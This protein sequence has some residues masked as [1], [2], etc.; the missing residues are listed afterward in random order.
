MRDI[1]E[2]IEKNI[3]FEMQVL[4]LRKNEYTVTEISSILH[5]SSEKVSNAIKSLTEK[6]LPATKYK[7]LHGKSMLKRKQRALE[8]LE[9][10]KTVKE[11]AYELEVSIDTV[12]KYIKE[13]IKDGKVTKEVL[14]RNAD[15]EL[16]SRVLELRNS[17]Y[18]KPQIMEELGLGNLSVTTIIQKLVENG[19]LKHTNLNPTPEETGKEAYIK[20]EIQKLIKSGCTI[21]EVARTLKIGISMA[22]NYTKDLISE[23]KLDESSVM[24]EKQY[25]LHDL[26]QM[27]IE[28]M[29]NRISR[30]QMAR[31]SKMSYNKIGPIINR[32]IKDNRI[33]ENENTRNPNLFSRKLKK[34]IDMRNKEGIIHDCREEMS[35]YE[36]DIRRNIIS[37][38]I[39]QKY[40]S[41]CKK[42]VECGGN[43]TREEVD[44]LAETIAYGDGKFSPEN[45]LFISNEY[46]K[47]G[48]Y[49]VARRLCATC[50]QIYGKNE[51]ISEISVTLKVAMEKQQAY[52]LLKNGKTNEEIMN[53][54]NLRQTDI[55]RMR[56]EYGDSRKTEVAV[57]PEV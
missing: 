39:Q 19:Q 42:I 57:E 52:N 45:L 17:G 3:N 27:L 16:E 31:E 18:T 1:N 11:I 34:E 41:C 44:I 21:C 26:E 8:L 23:G 56:R 37:E 46:R 36:R 15:L 14:N 54:T 2:A 4:E 10:G 38:A 5:V 28:M 49:A 33:K 55:I 51:L 43:L 6:G 22:Y 35:K 29:E 50:E 32:L 13:F 47:L 24:F 48:E 7:N 9:D 12:Y 40:A 25:G 20:N 30:V 53:A